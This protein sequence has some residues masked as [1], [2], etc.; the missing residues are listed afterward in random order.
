MSRI[1]TIKDVVDWGLCIGCGA[2]YYF[3]DKDAVTLINIESIGIRPSFNTK[4]CGTCS[5]C[6]SICPGFSLDTATNSEECNL[7]YSIDPLI[8][9]TLEIWEG[10]ASE[11]EV[12]YQ[13]SS[14]GILTALALYCLERE[15]MEF[16]LHTGMNPLIPWENKTIISKT[17]IDLLKSTGSRYAPSSPCDSMHL[18]EQSKKKCVFIGK[19][20]DAAAVRMLCRLRPGLDAKIGLILSFFCAGPPCTQGTLDL[21]RELEVDK[22]DVSDIRY[23]G[24]GWPGNFKVVNKD[25]NKSESLTYEESWG[26]LAEYHRSFRCHLCPDGLGEFG[27]ISCGD[28]WHKYAANGNPGQSLVLVR[29][30]K[31]KRL[32]HKACDAGY[33]D[34]APSSRG[35]VIAAQGLVNRRRYLFGRLLAMRLLAVPTPKL[36]G[37]QLAR[38][39]LSI[40]NKTKVKS[41][42]GTLARLLKRGLWHRN[43]IPAEFYKDTKQNNSKLI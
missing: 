2:C 14:G 23:R 27:D 37:F 34:L 21:L 42:V 30:G 6:L 26:K 31:G 7:E 3:C 38:D 25:G 28:A 35:E 24:L 4:I 12:R 29:S 15:N 19:P 10:H 17:R 39:W 13:A 22:D 20:C 1:K 36:T 41:I 5:D 43:S 11:E 40:S 8:G 33:I 18:I 32:L 9:P 16:V